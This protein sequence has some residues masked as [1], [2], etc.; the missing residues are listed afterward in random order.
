MESADVHALAHRSSRDKNSGILRL[1]AR[2]GGA[3]V[4]RERERERAAV[5]MTRNS[6]GK[7][8]PPRIPQ[9]KPL[10]Y[11]ERKR[12]RVKRK[13]KWES[14]GWKRIER[15]FRAYFPAEFIYGEMLMTARA[16]F[17]FRQI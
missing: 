6:S 4:L 1:A 5:K 14:E 15:I 11:Q 7:R 9:P 16:L 10:I 2:G 17:F 3:L 13:I 8:K 12:E